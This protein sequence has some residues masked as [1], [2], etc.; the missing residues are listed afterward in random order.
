MVTPCEDLA[1]KAQLEELKSQINKLLGETEDGGEIDVLTEGTLEGTKLENRMN[2]AQDAIQD[3]SIQGAGL[4]VPA[5][6]SYQ[7]VKEMQEG[8]LQ[9]IKKTGSGLVKPLTKVNTVAKAT[10]ATT[11]QNAAVG[12]TTAAA[13]GTAAASMAVLTSLVGMIGN[14]VVNIATVRILGN[15]ID[16]NE[17]AILSWNKDYTN[18]INIMSKQNNDLNAAQSD[19]QKAQELLDQQGSEIS[20]LQS[21]MGEANNSID[22]LNSSVEQANTSIKNLQTQNQALE[23]QLIEF[24]GEATAEIDNLKTITQTI[25]GDLET[26][27]ANIEILTQVNNAQKEEISKYQERTDELVDTVGILATELSDLAQEFNDLKT[28]ISEDKA[29]TDSKLKRA[30]AQII[31]LE[32]KLK[33]FDSNSNF[34]PSISPQGLAETQTKTLELTNTLAGNPKPQSQLQ[35]DPKTASI[36]GPFVDIFESLLPQINPNPAEVTDVQLSELETAILTGITANFNDLGLNNFDNRLTNIENN[37]TPSAQR[38]NTRQALCDS[39]EPGG[40]L[41]S[42]VTNPIR[43]DLGNINNG[44]NAANTGLG[45]LNAFLNQTILGNLQ[46]VHNS[47]LANNAVLTHATHGLQATRTF[48]T[49][50]WQSTRV[51]KILEYL[52]FVLALHNA[53]ML[54]RNIGASIGDAISAIANNSIDFIKNEEGSK[55]DIN[56]AIGNTLEGFLKA[57]LGVENYN[58]TKDTF[59]KY[60]RII[61]AASNIIWSIQSV[62]AGLAQGLQTVGNYTGRIGNALIRSGTVLENSYNWMNE[63]LTFKT[64]RIGQVQAVLD[65]AQTIENVASEISGATA[66]FR[67]AQQQVTGIG[68]QFN[69]IENELIVKE[70]ETLNQEATKKSNSQGAQPTQTDLTPDP[71]P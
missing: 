45:A 66:E 21:E 35:I 3:I 24:E 65:N 51:G 64:G 41:N 31:L 52:S 7:L 57:T 33:N 56:D 70:E 48:L 1:T 38:N 6:L 30:D 62:Q 63:N 5:A 2:L 28:E 9:W 53:A 26:A 50:A 13:A 55:I 68:D 42:N 8:K 61:N 43:N 29:I 23:Q 17:K 20:S 22:A 36:G 54:S 71:K 18:L 10:A 60:N 58:N 4:A 59:K 40:C 34:L 69:K 25:N 49:N 46:A 15:R 37:T 12:T 44:V 67:E 32:D 47:V 19:I 39:S 11:V 27:I 14:L 16:Q